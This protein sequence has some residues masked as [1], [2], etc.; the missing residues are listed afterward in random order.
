MLFD[1]KT[2]CRDLSYA[3]I[4]T[5]ICIHLEED[6]QRDHT[7]LRE[8]MS[9]LPSDECIRWLIDGYE[10]DIVGVGEAE[11]GGRESAVRSNV[12]FVI[13]ALLQSASIGLIF[14]TMV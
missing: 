10:R 13:C 14:T 8:H 12:L 6:R 1:S 7:D 11:G 2:R 3:F 9:A 5:S 4:L